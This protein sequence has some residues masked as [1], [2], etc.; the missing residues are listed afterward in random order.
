[1]FTGME[2]LSKPVV[3]ISQ[4]HMAGLSRGFGPEP[5]VFF[6]GSQVALQANIYRV[7][8]EESLMQ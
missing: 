5:P 8:F 2:S 1:M 4:D 7:V 3:S 6:W